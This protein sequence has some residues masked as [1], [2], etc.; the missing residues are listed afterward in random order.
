MCDILD[1][2]VMEDDAGE[3]PI[4]TGEITGNQFSSVS[5]HSGNAGIEFSSR[6]MNTGYDFFGRADAR[7]PR[8]TVYRRFQHTGISGGR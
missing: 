2:A 6:F 1:C 5:K 7:L 3:G 4:T 8:Q